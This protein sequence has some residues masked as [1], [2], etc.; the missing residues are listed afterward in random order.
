MVKLA[1]PKVTTISLP[2]TQ[3]AVQ[4]KMQPLLPPTA[5]PRK[6]KAET[7][8][9]SDTFPSDERGREEE[10]GGRGGR[11]TEGK[12]ERK[13]MDSVNSNKSKFPVKSPLPIPRPRIKS[14]K[15]EE[16]KVAS[17]PATSPIRPLP[18]PKTRLGNR[19]PVQQDEDE[20]VNV[21]SPTRT[22]P[23]RPVPRARIASKEESEQ[24]QRS[25]REDGEA[26]RGGKGAKG[27]RGGRGRGLAE[28]REKKGDVTIS[29][30]HPTP[31]KRTSRNNR[32]ETSTN[33]QR[34]LKVPMTVP[35]SALLR[36]S[37]SPL[38]P[39]TNRTSLSKRKK[40]GGIRAPHWNAPPP[41]PFSPPSTLTRSV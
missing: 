12:E 19:V 11:R 41:P 5:K 30:T 8:G 18:I 34:R 24:V 27:G 13:G 7:S 25:T 29:S 10:Q 1:H 15:D 21:F 3:R 4:A 40:G 26:D 31:Q 22:G 9:L 38:S 37:P 17:V 16:F 6:P 23:A 14:N 2:S 28:E 33:V 39:G 20:E 36:F 35:A 32:T